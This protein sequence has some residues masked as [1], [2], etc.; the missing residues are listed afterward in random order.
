MD[1]W[2]EVVD[3]IKSLPEQEQ[4]VL[5][6]RFVQGLRLPEVAAVMNMTEAEITVIYERAIDRCRKPLMTYI[7]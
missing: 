2:D 7:A 6:L 1:A 5:S 3:A 4:Q